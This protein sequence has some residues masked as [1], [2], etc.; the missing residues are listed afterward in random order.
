M[1]G[2]EK[3]FCVFTWLNGECESQSFPAACGVY[4]GTGSFTTTS[5][6]TGTLGMFLLGEWGVGTGGMRTFLSSSVAN[7][8]KANEPRSSPPFSFQCWHRGLEML[9]H[10][11]ES[12]PRNPRNPPE[13]TM[14]GRVRWSLGMHSVESVTY[15]LAELGE[16]CLSQPLPPRPVCPT[17]PSHFPLCFCS[18]TYPN[19]AR[20]LAPPLIS[21]L[22]DTQLLA[23]LLAPA[24]SLMHQSDLIQPPP[25]P[26]HP[27]AHPG[28]ANVEVISSW[29]EQ[30]KCQWE[31]ESSWAVCGVQPG[32]RKHHTHFGSCD[33]YSLVCGVNLTWP[34]LQ[35]HFKQVNLL[36]DLF[37]STYLF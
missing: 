32:Y 25:D 22:T 20:L 13:K 33:K 18:L 12:S 21:L 11:A 9:T 10:G 3:I 4:G 23:F 2:C 36:V 28:A 27:V 6:L 14:G 5:R 35:A 15:L 7:T 31:C 8:L 24:S 34:F 16:P 19:A 26:C 17:S 1:F 37:N 29:W 30:N